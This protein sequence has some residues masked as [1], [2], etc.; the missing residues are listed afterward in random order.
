MLIEWYTWN[1]DS[2]RI[3]IFAVVILQV[4]QWQIY[5]YIMLFVIALLHCVIALCHLLH[6]IA[7]DQL[8]QMQL[9]LPEFIYIFA[10]AWW[11]PSTWQHPKKSHHNPCFSG[12]L[13]AIVG[14]EIILTIQIVT[15]LVLVEYSL[16]YNYAEKIYDADAV[17]ILVLVEYSLQFKSFDSWLCLYF[18]TILVLVEYS[19]Q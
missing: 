14:D 10:I 5:Y 16:Q 4:K 12:I 9:L 6:V 13:F 8:Q 2:T 11:N 18:V 17:T 3:I 1:K 7:I 15:I 19:L